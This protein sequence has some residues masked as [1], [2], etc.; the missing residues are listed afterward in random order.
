MMDLLVPAVEQFL[1]T[2]SHVSLDAPF[3]QLGLTSSQLIG[4]V[5]HVAKTLKLELPV[6]L[7][8][9]CPTLRKMASTLHNLR[10]ASNDGVPYTETRVVASTP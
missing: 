10:N 6:T 1:G 9:D 8:F 5:E 3:L 2:D 4:L 7:S